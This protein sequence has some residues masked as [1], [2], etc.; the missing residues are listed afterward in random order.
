MNALCVIDLVT[1]ETDRKFE[2]AGRMAAT[3]IE[4]IQE[5]GDCLPH[6]LKGRGFSLDEIAAHFHMAYSLANVE[7][8]L[9]NYDSLPKRWR[10]KFHA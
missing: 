3:V 5:Q 8:K 1:T 7:L 9:M 4:I 10:E 2:P 6:D